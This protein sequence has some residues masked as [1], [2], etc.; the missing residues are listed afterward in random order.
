M[1]N[2]KTASSIRKTQ[3]IPE[4]NQDDGEKTWQAPVQDWQ[5]RMLREPQNAGMADKKRQ[6]ASIKRKRFR[7]KIGMTGEKHGRSLHK[8]DRKNAPGT[9]KYRND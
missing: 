8:T 7:I 4:K 6:V 2:K 5:K 9:P 3:K 1:T